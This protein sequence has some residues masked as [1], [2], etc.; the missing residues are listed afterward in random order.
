MIVYFI[1]VP[2]QVCYLSGGHEIEFQEIES[3][4]KIDQEIES[5]FCKIDQEI[6]KPLGGHY[7]RVF[8]KLNLK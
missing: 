6:E 8:L 1:Y 5:F 4:C 7:F 3:Y 2:S